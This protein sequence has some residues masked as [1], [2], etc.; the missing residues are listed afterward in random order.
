MIKYYCT[1]CQK[2]HH[3]GKI[4]KKHIKDFLKIELIFFRM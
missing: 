4:Y 3:R 2:Y 1:K